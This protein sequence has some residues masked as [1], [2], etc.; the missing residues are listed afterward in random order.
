MA[1]AA[2]FQ[3][4]ALVLAAVAIAALANS[5]LAAFG[6]SLIHAYITLRAISLLLALALIFAGAGALWREK[7]PEMG[8]SWKVGAFLTTL[9][10]FFLLEFGDKTQFL[11]L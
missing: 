9:G 1:L 5:A 8:A 10:C 6:G 4:P 3:R 11:T 7:T 2:R